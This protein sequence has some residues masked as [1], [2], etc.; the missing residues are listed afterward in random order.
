M[1]G[2]S[3][4]L[5]VWIIFRSRDVE[6]TQY[7]HLHMLT[8]SWVNFK[9]FS[10][11]TFQ[12]FTVGLQTYFFLMERNLNSDISKPTSFSRICEFVKIEKE[13]HA[14]LSTESPM[15]A[16]ISY[17]MI[18]HTKNFSIIAFNHSFNQALKHI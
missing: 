8:F 11:E 13:Y 1:E 17:I 7:A 2:K 4:T 15:I 6:W 10:S 3:P 9:N 12:L 16:T 14:P 18:Q 5:M